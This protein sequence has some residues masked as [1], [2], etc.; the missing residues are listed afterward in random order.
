MTPPEDKKLT[1]IVR[2]E[3]GCLGPNGVDVVDDFC[4]QAHK[5][6]EP[7]YPEFIVWQIESRDDLTLPEKDYHIGHKRLD[8]IKATKYLALFGQ[9]L[10]EIEMELEDKLVALI[11][12]YLG[13]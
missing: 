13:Y 2:V 1:L 12:D 8:N 10:T 3:S 11:N 6:F 9:N 5:V 7:L 4:R